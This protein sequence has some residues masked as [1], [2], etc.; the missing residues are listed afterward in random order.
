MSKDLKTLQ[1]TLEPKQAR[2]K[3]L[4][5]KVV[6]GAL[7]DSEMG[8]LRT[9]TTEID[10]LVTDVEVLQRAADR[11]K[12]KARAA[13]D[14]KAPEQE[15]R[16]NV[17]FLEMARALKSNRPLEGRIAEL[18]QEGEKEARI[19]GVDATEGIALPS[20]MHPASRG[21]DAATAATAGNL[22]P[23]LQQ[24]FTPALRPT[25]VLE[26]LGATFLTGLT[27]NLEFP[28][29][30]ALATASFT[31]E[32]GT[33]SETTPT[34][35]KPTL[36]PKRLATWSKTT[37]QLL[38]QSSMNV[39]QWLE[40]E[41]LSAEMRKINEVAI[42]GGGTNEPTGILAM[43]LPSGHVLKIGPDANTGLAVS[44]AHLLELERLLTDAYADS[45]NIK[46]LTTAKVRAALKNLPSASGI[47]PMVW[48]ANNTV[49]G[50]DAYASPLV[51][52]NLAV[53]TTAG[54]GNA[55]IMGDF[56]RL[57]VGNWGVRYLTLDNITGSKGGEMEIILNS[58]WDTQVVHKAAFVCIKDA[59]A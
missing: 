28:A 22:I 53:G 1:A 4:D 58:F 52:N 32:T 14:K 44:R 59:L 7:T 35:K 47:A 25:S 17:N 43:T 38:A 31:T 8:E 54:V 5:E 48:E 29:G 42:K 46:I 12:G 45:G 34:T 27:G 19:A 23:T 16:E 37:L 55:L 24:P 30:D 49:V 18:H 36:T 39:A 20:W 41:M 26:M 51:P 6:G 15:M 21:L 13:F 56:S 11:A 50:Y 57:I 33:A 9:L 2:L 3:E 40:R 10:E